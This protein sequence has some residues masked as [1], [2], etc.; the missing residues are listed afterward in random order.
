MNQGVEH[1]RRTIILVREFGH[2]NEIERSLSLVRRSVALKLT[3]PTKTTLTSRR[4]TIY[5]RS[6]GA[7]PSRMAL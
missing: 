3:S 2:L 4:Q 1:N 5:R 6:S 7:S